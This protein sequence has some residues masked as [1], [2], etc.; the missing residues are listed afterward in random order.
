MDWRSCGT[1]D[2]AVPVGVMAALDVWQSPKSGEQDDVELAANAVG[3]ASSAASKQVI[4]IRSIALTIFTPIQMRL[5][6]RQIDK[7]KLPRMIAQDIFHCFT[8]V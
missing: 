5:E 4:L 6:C 3:A 8:I 1:L 2:T 7:Q